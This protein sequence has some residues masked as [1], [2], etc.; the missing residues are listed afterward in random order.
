MKSRPVLSC[1]IMGFILAALVSVAHADVLLVF[2]DVGG[3]T[4]VAED[5]QAKLAALGSISGHID[6]FD[7]TV[8]TPSLATLQ[9]YD[10][11]MHWT[12]G[13]AA[14][15]VTLGDNLADY[16]DA[17]GGVVLAVFATG[18]SPGECLAGRWSTGG[19]DPITPLGQA[20]GAMS[21][22]T[23]HDAGHLVMHGVS[24][25]S[26]SN[27]YYGTGSVAGGATRIADWANGAPLAVELGGKATPILSLNLFPI[28]TDVDASGWSTSTDGAVLMANAL[29]YVMGVLIDVSPASKFAPTGKYQGTFSPT[30]RDYTLTNFSGGAIDWSVSGPAWLNLAPSSGTALISGGSATITASLNGAMAQGMAPGVYPGDITFSDVTNSLDVVREAELVVQ[31]WLEVTPTDGYV[32]FGPEGGPFQVGSITSYVI[33]NTYTGIV[34]WTLTTPAWLTASMTNATVASG[35]SRTVTL[36][37]NTAMAETMAIGAHA[38]AITL[39][40][41]T[42]AT[43]QTRNATLFVQGI[44]Y[45]DGALTTG[46]NDGSSWADAIHGVDCLQDGVTT[47]AVDRSSVWVAEGTYTRKLALAEGVMVYGGFSNGD[48]SWADQ[49]PEGK[50]TIIDTGGQ[51]PVVSFAAISMAGIDGFTIT[52]GDSPSGGGGIRCVGTASS[53]FISDCTIIGNACSGRGA[54]IYC[55]AGA[56]PAITDCWIVGNAQHDVNRDFGGGICCDGASPTIT[57]CT[58]A[59]NIGRYGG[60]LGCLTGASPTVADCIISANDAIT[61]QGTPTPNGGGGGGVFAHDQSSPALSNCIIS[62]NYARNWGGG[63][64][65]CQGTSSPTLTNCTI[66]KNWAHHTD[67][68]DLLSGIVVNTGSRPLLLNCI[69]EGMPNGAVYEEDVASDVYARYGLFYSNGPY[70]FHDFDD[71]ANYTGGIDINT[72][73]DSCWGNVTAVSP[74]PR[75]VVGASGTWSAA[76][77]YSAVTNTTTLTTSGSPFAAD[78]LVGRFVNADTSQ[79]RQ[80]FI[81]ANTTNT[82][83]VVNDITSATGLEGYADNGDAFQVVDYRLQQGP[84]ASPC[85][86][87]GDT[88]G[89]PPAPPRDIRGVPR[90]QGTRVDI[91]AYEADFTAPTV[92]G[93]VSVTPNPTN[94]TEVVFRVTFSEDVHYFDDASDL[95]ITVFQNPSLTYSS[96]EV[97]PESGRDV[98][99]VTFYG[100]SGDGQLFFSVVVGPGV[101]DF[102]GNALAGSPASTIVTIDQTAP[103]VNAPA[104]QGS[105]ETKALSVT[106]HVSF[107]EPVQYVDASDFQVTTGPGATI[108]TSPF[109]A[110]AVSSSGMTLDSLWIVTVNTGEMEGTIRLD[111]LDDGSITD[112]ATNGLV[113]GSTSGDVHAVDTIHPTVISI[114]IDGAPAAL[115]TSVDFVVTFREPVQYVDETDFEPVWTAS[116]PATLDPSVT[117]VSGADAVWTVTVD[118]GIM[119]GTLG[120]AVSAGNNIEDLVGNGLDDLASSGEVHTVDTVVPVC[121]SITHEYGSDPVNVDTLEFKALF[122]EDVPNLTADD[123]DFGAADPGVIHPNDPT[124]APSGQPHEYL[125][126]FTNVSGDGAFSFTILTDSDITDLV[127]NPLDAGSIPAGQV[128]VVDNTPPV[129]TFGTP[130][131][132]NPG[133]ETVTEK[134]NIHGTATIPFAYS[135]EDAILL[136][137]ANIHVQADGT[138]YGW[139][140][141]VLNVTGDHTREIVLTN[142]H[143]SG[144]VWITI[145]AG[146]SSDV[147]GNLDLGPEAP[148]VHFEVD[149]TGPVVSIAAPDP[150]RTAEGPVVYNITF[151]DGATYDLEY[152][153]ISGNLILNKGPFAE[154]TVLVD[155]GTTA[156]P[157]VTL[158]GCEGNTWLSV[159]VKA[160]AAWDE[161]GNTNLQTTSEQVILDNVGPQC[162]SVTHTYVGPTAASSIEFS[163]T[164]T[165]AVYN[166]NNSGDILVIHETPPGSTYSSGVV[167]VDSG[168]HIHYTIT[169]TGVGAMAPQYGGRFRIT[170]RD[171]SDIR[172]ISGNA[173]AYSGLETSDWVY[174]DTQ[175]ASVDSITPETVGPTNQD[176]IIFVVVFNTDVENFDRTDLTVPRTGSVTCD[177]VGIAVVPSSGP[178]D[179]YTVTVPD[180]AGDG[181]LRL[182]ISGSS[183]IIRHDTGVG[184]GGTMTSQAVRID[185]T[186]PSATAIT[187]ETVP[188]P[189]NQDTLAFTVVFNEKALLFDDASDLAIAETDTVTHTGVTVVDKGAGTEYT[190]TVTGIDGDGTMQLAVSTASGI[191][192]TLGNPIVGSVTSAAV[193]FQ[194]DLDGPNA[195]SI[196]PTTPALIRGGTVV[197]AV[198]FDEPVFGFD[199]SSDLIVTATGVTF[200]TTQVLVADTGDH[201]HYT[202]TFSLVA[203]TGTLGIRVRAGTGIVDAFGNPF[204]ASMVGTPVEVDNTSPTIHFS[205]PNPLSTVDGPVAYAVYYEDAHLDASTI[206]LTA[207]DILLTNL[208]GKAAPTVQV[209]GTG[210]TRTVTIGGLRDSTLG[211][212]LVSIEITRSGTAYDLVG[213]SASVSAQ[214]PPFTVTP[215]VPFPVAWWPVGAALAVAGAWAVRRRQRQ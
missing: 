144:H 88:A 127:G 201:V 182:G 191:T 36:T 41:V 131:G 99:L 62:G 128:L 111:V 60:G 14:D 51:G 205:Q 46:A 45:V 1:V 32:A 42:F 199:T 113:A 180:I 115:D 10:A 100:V 126:T 112:A 157:R 161:L 213:N 7:A 136:S 73:A 170:V 39:N 34:S 212:G 31:D 25:L 17:G 204:E 61:A 108:V 209:Q 106:Y 172:D 119:E 165:E 198:A 23:I 185:N 151:I 84:P 195:V 87:A 70:D 158:H 109:V 22:G 183:D 72:K 152:Q 210:S 150:P 125:V 206:D 95:N 55:K 52:G 118:T 38:D 2:S 28:S 63:A 50:P 67:G 54:G 114:L 94:V 171:D 101:Q 18:S 194:Q 97:T 147:A 66:S 78:E 169:V 196:V 93:I 162:T 181:T 5:L 174:I 142:L 89:V 203:G 211:L 11:V 138:V 159:T 207:G 80:A 117:A 146:T 77:V 134:V 110:S 53:C 35:A 166:F 215:Y 37:L 85:K 98:Y 132:E 176:S 43:T 184:L 107:C 186:G 130:T 8:D 187:P 139:D 192:D 190:V 49:D 57:G 81:V 9:A 82:I 143:G 188:V 120:L 33:K 200:D 90:P 133:H 58:I 202:A 79:P 124:I 83:T 168:D 4:S 74:D 116:P 3:N 104:L 65:Y 164:F 160:N 6:L 149:N 76:P 175:T 69:L 103:T 193:Q 123:L 140:L 129:L 47:A 148:C 12:N 179:V 26:G 155:F 68:Y 20:N 177:Q 40:N 121:L 86:D 189:T 56:A 197:F 24:A 48:T 208:T 105:P 15:H 75:F 21:L 71:S 27:I 91:G 137:L 122:S 59:G 141:P 167:V 19:Y 135:G 102:A 178:E 153:D 92:N 29:N 145:D 163:A 154:A 30:T 44:V 96:V 173:L 214:S 13:D 156:T 64:L 16:V